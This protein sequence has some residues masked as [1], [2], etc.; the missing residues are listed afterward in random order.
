MSLRRETISM[1]LHNNSVRSVE[2][3]ATT[4][5]DADWLPLAAYSALAIVQAVN[6][7]NKEIVQTCDNMNVCS[8]VS[9]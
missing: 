6:T 9:V 5:I 4:A 3:H 7:T 8:R 1:K 2:T